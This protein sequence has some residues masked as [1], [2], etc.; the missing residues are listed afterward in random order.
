MIAQIPQLHHPAIVMTKLL[1]QRSLIPR[2]RAHHRCRILIIQPIEA[3]YLS[4]LHVFNKRNLENFPRSR[5]VM[6]LKRL[7]IWAHM[8]QVYPLRRQL[9][10][11]PAT[12]SM[13]KMHVLVPVVSPG[14]TYSR[15]T[16]REMLRQQ[17]QSPSTCSH[18]RPPRLRRQ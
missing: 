2:L 3:S 17:D 5:K 11:D 13:H 12:A 8:R 10:H 4:A 1:L 6:E 16:A 9:D 18:L 7:T 15:L 14:K